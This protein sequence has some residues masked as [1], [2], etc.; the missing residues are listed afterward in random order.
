MYHTTEILLICQKLKQLYGNMITDVGKKYDMS[1]IEVDILLFLSNNPT[2]DTAKDIVEI[3]QIAKSYVSKTVE[4]L[5]EKEMILPVLDKEDRRKV[6]LKVSKKAGEVV[7]EA[8]KVQKDYL[9]I[10]YKDIT[11]EEKNILKIS[12]EKVARNVEEELK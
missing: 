5:V 1:R 8:R 11:T 9:K 4:Y 12:M 7:K 10:I 2:C 3:R 6:H